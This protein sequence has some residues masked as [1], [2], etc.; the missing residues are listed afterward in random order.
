MALNLLAICFVWFSTSIF[1]PKHPSFL[2][3]LSVCAITYR[4]R[5]ILTDYILL[6]QIY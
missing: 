5:F 4:N 2:P 1:S 6:G 3:Y